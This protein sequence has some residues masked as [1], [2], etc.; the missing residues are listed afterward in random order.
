MFCVCHFLDLARVIR[1][2]CEVKWTRWTCSPVICRHS[3]C[4][5]VKCSLVNFVTEWHPAFPMPLLTSIILV[6]G[7]R[8]GV[9]TE[10]SWWTGRV[11]HFA[12]EG[13]A[14]LQMMH[15]V[16]RIRQSIFQWRTVMRV[17][18]LLWT[19]LTEASF[20]TC[21][22]SPSLYRNSCKILWRMSLSSVM[23]QNL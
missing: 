21:N 13:K 9:H 23:A 18:T 2:K 6:V 22:L 5:I 14:C 8:R 12:P 16:V 10:I 1:E 4:H 11:S 3:R 20:Y 17:D 15:Q 19:R 7:V